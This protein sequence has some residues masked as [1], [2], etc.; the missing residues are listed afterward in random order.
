MIPGSGRSPGGGNGLFAFCH[1][2]DVICIS[3][4]TDISL[5]VLI[6]VCASSS[7]EFLMIYSSYKLNKQDDNIQ[8]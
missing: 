4:V 6:P 2:N 3:E 8:P 7:P 1:K 5:R